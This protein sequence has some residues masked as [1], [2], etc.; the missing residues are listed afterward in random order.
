[1]KSRIG[2]GMSI[3]NKQAQGEV[4]FQLGLGMTA[5]SIEHSGDSFELTQLSMHLPRT[6]PLVPSY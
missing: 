4:E 6:C 3:S 2:P 1:M 5:H